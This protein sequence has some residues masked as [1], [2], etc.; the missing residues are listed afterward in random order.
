VTRLSNFC[1]SRGRGTLRETSF[2]T[3][4]RRATRTRAHHFC[5]PVSTRRPI[6][7]QRLGAARGL[8]RKVLSVEWL[9]DRIKLINF[10]RGEWELDLLAVAAVDA[11]KGT[12]T[13]IVTRENLSKIGVKDVQRAW[14]IR[15]R[16][17]R[18]KPRRGCKQGSRHSASHL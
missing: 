9:G 2:S 3:K 5:C 12:P 4:R 10:L 11:M 7:P 17:A 1:A 8:V 15:A 16:D 13:M 6:Q 18:H 14:K